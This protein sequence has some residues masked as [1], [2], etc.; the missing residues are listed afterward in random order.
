M[1]LIFPI[2]HQ[3]NTFL[4]VMDYFVYIEFTHME[5]PANNLF[6]S[7]LTIVEST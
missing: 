2:F 1:Q 4:D 3:I 6:I 5:F 7:S